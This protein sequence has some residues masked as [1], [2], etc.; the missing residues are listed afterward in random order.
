MNFD[1]YDERGQAVYYDGFYKRWDAATQMESVT[2][3]GLDEFQPLFD[4]VQNYAYY[5]K[6][7]VVGTD[8]DDGY[9]HEC[10]PWGFGMAQIYYNVNGTQTTASWEVGR[11]RKKPLVSFAE[12]NSTTADKSKGASLTVYAEPYDIDVRIP[13][14]LQNYEESKRYTADEY[15]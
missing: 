6:N 10:F 13:N 12:F 1:V 3:V 14:I 2:E 9:C 8:Y 7:D 15:L 11:S 5:L 4:K